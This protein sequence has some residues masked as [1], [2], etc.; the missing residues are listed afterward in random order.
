MGTRDGRSATVS[1]T[2]QPFRNHL[3]SKQRLGFAALSNSR[4]L[5]VGIGVMADG[6]QPLALALR[7]GTPLRSGAADPATLGRPAT[8]RSGRWRSPSRRPPSAA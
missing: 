3:I 7:R 2:C 8:L 5:L 6:S 1:L 4:G